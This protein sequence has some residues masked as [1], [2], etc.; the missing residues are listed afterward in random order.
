MTIAALY[1]QLKDQLAANGVE[2]A[3]FEAKQLMGFVLGVSP[4]QLLLCSGEVT[5]R[6]AD[7]LLTLGKKRGTGYPLQ[8]L[9]GEWSFYGQTFEVGEGV[10]IPRADTEVLCDVAI[11]WV[12]GQSFEPPPRILD[13]C[14][15]SGCIAITLA[16]ELPGCE[17]FALERSQQ[18]IGYLEQNCKRHHSGVTLLFEDARSPD[19]CLQGA[20]HL[21]VC[22]PPY[23]SGADL[24]DLQREVRHEPVMALAGGEDG[25]DFY[26]DLLPIW[27]KRLVS[28]GALL[29]EVG[30]GQYEV[31]AALMREQ[32]LEQVCWHQDGGGIDRVVMGIRR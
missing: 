31:V 8:Y 18:A 4:S 17:V 5:K 2:A 14:S 24:S 19:T 26:R 9:L 7:Q 6:Q 29:F 32:G 30:I 12:K 10:L 13:L 22:N 11:D 28:G 20:L 15:G 16:R 23:L 3:P 25:Y 21:I 1:R 27:S